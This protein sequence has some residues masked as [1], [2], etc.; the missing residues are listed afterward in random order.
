LSGVLVKEMSGV[1]VKEM[2]ILTLV[3]MMREMMA[4]LIGV[5]PL[6]LNQVRI[7]ILMYPRP[8][9]RRKKVDDLKN[10]LKQYKFS[11]KAFGKI[12]KRKPP[13]DEQKMKDLSSKIPSIMKAS[14]KGVE[15]M[16]SF[17]RDKRTVLEIIKGI[18][19]SGLFTL[20]TA[21]SPIN[22]QVIPAFRYIFHAANEM[23][24]KDIAR[25]AMLRKL[26]EAV[27][28]CQQVQAREILRI[29]GDL[30]NQN[31]TFESQ[32]QYLL[33]K[34]K[35]ETLDRFIS[36]FHKDCDEDHTKVKPAQ[37]RAHLKSAYIDML[38]EQLGLEAVEAARGDRF[39]PEVRKELAN[40]VWGGVKVEAI[41]KML[42]RQLSLELF[43]QYLLA[44]INNQSDNADRLINK[45][46]IFKWV[47][48]NMSL[49][50]ANKVFWDEDR[51]HE[52]VGMDP[53]KPLDKNKFHPFLSQKFLLRIL[54]EMEF[55]ERK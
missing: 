24:P 10:K 35:E 19:A 6:L 5:S 11:S 27:Q 17:T 20:G 3:M 36:Q 7:L 2:K 21:S 15:K 25:V 53:C 37:Q 9:L 45:D 30:T 54:T 22:R 28:D 51:A 12:A 40:G 44:D 49:E 47:E 55:I 52:Y 43:I 4:V 14:V 18:Y 31:Q 41:F 32:I 46:C 8:R 16:K 26:A 1:L 48:K 34:Q 39:L 42:T 29:F 23:K 33:L 13:I 50:N 38:G